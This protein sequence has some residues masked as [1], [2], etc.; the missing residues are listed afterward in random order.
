MDPEGEVAPA[1]RERIVFVPATTGPSVT[2]SSPLR[3][4]LALLPRFVPVFLLLLTLL[5]IGYSV[6][7]VVVDTVGR[8]LLG[9]GAAVGPF[10]VISAAIMTIPMM[11]TTVLDATHYPLT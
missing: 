9:Y 7:V 11:L 8:G 3:Q 6:A 2:D 1:P 5:V 10:V 4:V